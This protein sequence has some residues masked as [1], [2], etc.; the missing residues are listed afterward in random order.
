MSQKPV[1]TIEDITNSALDERRSGLPK[2]SATRG[3]EAGF[4]NLETRI[5]DAENVDVAPNSFNAAL[6]RSAL[7]HF[8]NPT[9]ALAGVCRALKP[10]GKCSVTVY[11]TSEKNPFHGL[12]LSIASRLAKIP[13]PAWGEPGMFALSGP[14][15]LE[16]CYQKAGFRDVT[17]RAVPVQRHFPSTAEAVSAM[18]DYFPRLQTLLNKLSDAKRAQDWSEIEE[19]LSQFEGVERIRGARRVAYRSRDEV[20]PLLA[21][22]PIAI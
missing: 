8:S 1:I 10:S 20:K 14:G 19:G 7:M 9:K 18:K 3:C 13:L 12:P 5:M 6:C 15:M 11:S 16:E 22:S 2:G 21:V 4:T 17:V